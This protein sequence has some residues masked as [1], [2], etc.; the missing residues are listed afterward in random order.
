MVLLLADK[1]KAYDVVDSLR[2]RHWTCGCRIL[3]ADPCLVLTMKPMMT[4]AVADEMFPDNDI[5]DEVAV[6]TSSS[7][8]QLADLTAN[9]KMVHADF[10]NTFDD[11]FDDENL[12]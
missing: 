4:S 3:F 2:L 5:S 9:E 6:E 10:Y 7:A 12:D 1:A 8:M 11:L